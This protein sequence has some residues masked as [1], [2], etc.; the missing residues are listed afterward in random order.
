MHDTHLIEKIYQS[1]IA[2][3]EQNGITRVN[4]IAIEVDQC[5][6]IE[7]EHLLAHLV[8][9]DNTIF[10]EWTSVHMEYKP[11]EMLTAVIKRIDGT[12]E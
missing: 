5:S 2:L 11:Y 10:G 12:K 9:R 6:H 7:A 4:N 1:I 8:D 3:C